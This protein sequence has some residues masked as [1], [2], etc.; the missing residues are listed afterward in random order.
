MSTVAQL[1]S[2]QAERAGMPRGDDL[3]VFSRDEVRQL[4]EYLSDPAMA[5]PA[6][7]GAA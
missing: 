3:V 7:R 5:L 6:L 2:S 4:V 1:V